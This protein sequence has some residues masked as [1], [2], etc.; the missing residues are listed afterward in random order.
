MEMKKE[1]LVL[2]F[3][4]VLHHIQAYKVPD[5]IWQNMDGDRFETSSPL[6]SQVG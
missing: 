3:K 5:I 1:W 4:Q 6:S 2:R